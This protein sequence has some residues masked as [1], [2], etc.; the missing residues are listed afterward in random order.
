[1]LQNLP[2]FPDS[3]SS[4]AGQ[5]DGIY[6][7]GVAVSLF[8]SALI[9]VLVLVLAVKYRRR[10]ADQIGS[11]E[12]PPDI[13]EVVWSVVPLGILM[14]MFFWGARVFFTLRTTPPGAV[15][16]YA[17]AKRWM[18]KFQHPSGNR[19][20]NELHVPVG[21]T[22][23]VKMTSED[24]IHDF[25]VPAFRTKYDVIPGRYT[26]VWF[27]ATKPGE[28]HLFCAEYCGAEHSRMVG[29]VV[30]MEPSEYQA[31]L[32]H[33]NAGQAPAASGAELFGTLACNTC[34]K[35]DSA[36]RAP[37]LE[38]VYGTDVALLGGATAKFDDDYIRESIL[39]P[40]AKVVAGYQP[41][42]PTFKGQISED[43]LMQLITYVKSLSPKK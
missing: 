31:W 7:F 16:Y 39:N 15:E 3:A 14:V 20:I 1:M 35:S 17:V 41:I 26:S 36:A 2:L 38:N 29:R 13:L 27:K 32:T 5:V 30:V 12:H 10:R 42:M 6:L 19:E 8:F 43:Q 4:F 28:Y 21:Q 9:A 37:K 18:W 11:D 24:V 34:H 33:G 22:V 25:F 40:Q 23:V